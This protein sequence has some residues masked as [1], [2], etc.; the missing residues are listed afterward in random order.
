MR[1]LSSSLA[2]VLLS[3]VAGSA[4]ASTDINGLYD[5]R[6]HGMGGTGVA[7]IDSAGALAINP[8]LLDQINKLTVT[9]DL[10]G[11]VSQS[12]LPYSVYHQNP[13]GSYYKNYETV[14]GK[15]TKGVLPFLGVAVRV[16]KRIVLGSGIYPV[17]PQGLRSTYRPAPDQFPNTVGTN[18]ITNIQ[19]E[20]GE[21]LAIRVFD[22][23]S[24][25]LMWR[26]TY[27]NQSLSTPTPN[28]VPPAGVQLDMTRDPSNPSVINTK[29]DID[30][31]NFK[32]MQ[33]G[34]L[35]KP[36]PNL[37]LGFTY[38]NKVNVRG[39]GI[40]KT[41]VGGML[42]NI[43]TEGGVSSPHALRG[44]FA[45]ALLKNRLLVAGDFKYN[46]YKE[47]WKTATL[48]LNYPGL[49][50]TTVKTPTN[51]YN[52]WVVEV[53]AEYKVIDIVAVRTGYTILKSATNP[54]Y[55]QGFMAPPGY[56]HLAMAGVGVKLGDHFDV[57]VAAGAVVLQSMVKTPTEYNV[58]SGRYGNRGA[59]FSFSGSYRM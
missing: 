32:G 7:F 39:D 40:T 21:A 59:Q 56:S 38:R 5:A 24:L 52:S 4:A 19:V 44:G 12:Q 55:A 22:N 46:F 16:H 42:V 34:V 45:L 57:D 51:W 26:I 25:A 3:L 58:G 53:G 8:A 48:E 17:F 11:I 29:Q 37:R 2:L 15:R 28:G 31:W 33:F 13:D 54:D 1:V 23:L 49:G 41:P 9:A 36:L 47:A 35:Y 10:F 20:A 18:E 14:R 27:L 6:S 43:P 50:P 30:G